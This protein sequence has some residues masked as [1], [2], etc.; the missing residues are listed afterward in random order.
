MSRRPSAGGAVI[1]CAALLTLIAACDAP[2]A[3]PCDLIASPS[4]SDS[5]AGTLSSPYRTAQRL[6]DELR[7]GQTG[8][9]RGGAYVQRGLSFRHGGSS[10]SPLTLRSYPG[11]R[12]SISGGTVEVPAGSNF[13]TLSGL[14]IDGSAVADATIFLLAYDTVIE[15][16]DITNRNAGTQCM[17]IGGNGWGGSAARVTIRR[18]RIHDCGRFSAG[19]QE[20]AIYFENASD[21][22]VTGN[23]IWG[24][25]GF[26]LH[27][28]PNAQRTFVAQ[29][30]IDDN[31]YGVIVAGDDGYT[32]ND[33]TIRQNIITNTT[34][35]NNLRTWWGGDI[36][37]GNVA[38]DNCVFNGADGDVG[39][40]GGMVVS[41]TVVA[42]PQ[43]VDRAKRDYRLTAGSPCL[44]VVGYDVAA[45]MAAREA[46]PAVAGAQPNATPVA[47]TAPLPTGWALR[48]ACRRL[49]RTVV[50]CQLRAR[51]PVS[52]RPRGSIVVSARGAQIVRHARP[53]PNGRLVRRVRGHLP[54]RV[55]HVTV[56]AAF[57]A[58]GWSAPVT[59]RV[60]R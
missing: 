33:N 16:S 40:T 34:I 22:R 43:Y 41:G 20:H 27:I 35:G 7:P 25:A 24:S 58:A 1:L 36:G 2:A 55:H 47:T 59:V 26:A 29:N 51:P 46:E 28:Y 6:A 10:G 44:A 13:V 50:G 45:A 32:S 30:V 11:E 21:T 3:S 60:R 12:A 19:D 54:R 39:Y 37:G 57:G 56:R 4:G 52:G 15:D 8:C 17:L 14:A 38:R 42:D 53:R 5:G 23:V 48:A 18:N 49:R 9:L 31:R